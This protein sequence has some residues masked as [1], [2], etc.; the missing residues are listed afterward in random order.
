MLKRRLGCWRTRRFF[1]T[2]SKDLLRK[3]VTPAVA[4]RGRVRELRAAGVL[5][6][7]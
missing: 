3:I 7:S 5:W 2:A 1:N 6:S 4:K